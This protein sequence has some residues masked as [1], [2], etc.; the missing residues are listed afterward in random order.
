MG[1]GGNL[2][3]SWLG[4]VDMLTEPEVWMIDETSF[5]KAGVVC[6]VGVARQYWAPCR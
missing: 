1:G 2:K 3:G 6:Q 4:V 5:P